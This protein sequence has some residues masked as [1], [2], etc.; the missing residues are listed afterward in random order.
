MYPNPV[1]GARLARLARAGDRLFGR[2]SGPTPCGARQRRAAAAGRALRG[3]RALVVASLGGV[4]GC[5]FRKAPTAPRKPSWRRNLAFISPCHRAPGVSPLAQPGHGAASAP[6]RTR[7][8]LCSHMHPCE[9]PRCRRISS[10][11]KNT[12]PL[13]RAPAHLST[14]QRTSHITPWL[15]KPQPSPARLGRRGRTGGGRPGRART[16]PA[17][18]PWTRS[19][20]Q[21]R[22]SPWCTGARG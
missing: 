5:T 10:L 18:A 16:A 1:G 14:C 20:W 3:S 4:M 7:P 21:T 17:R 19:G 12:S 2:Y 6:A 8:A 15:W 22:W 11:R 13:L 9:Q